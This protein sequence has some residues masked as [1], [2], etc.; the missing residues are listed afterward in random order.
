MDATELPVWAVPLALATVFGLLLLAELWRP[1]RSAQRRRWPVNLGLGLT[2]AVLVR[3][4]AAAAPVAAAG[5]AQ[6]QGVGLFNLLPVPLWAELLLVVVAMDFAIYWQHRALHV[7]PWGWALHRL[8]H[9]DGDFDVT[10]G[11]RF[12]PGEALLSMLYKAGLVVLLGASPLA[13]LLFE[14]YLAIGSMIEHANVRLPARADAA[15]RRVWVTPDV[16]RVHHSAHEEDHNH[17]Y[18]FAIGVWDRWFGTYRA[19]PGGPKIGL[20]QAAGAD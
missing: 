1:V 14:A 9:A 19:A 20:P 16:H 4:V 8:H 2:N 12:H 3:L 7:L 15:L 17:N 13:A 5:W 11:V 18:G 10:T 6:A